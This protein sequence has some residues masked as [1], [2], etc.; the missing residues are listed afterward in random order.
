MSERTFIVQTPQ[1]HGDD[2][3][4]WQETLNRQMRTWKV[5]YQL[6]PDGDYG[7]LTRDLTASVCHGLGLSS[8]A[9]AMKGGV[10]PALR[11]KLRNKELTAA[12]SDRYHDRAEWRIDFRERHR[13]KDVAPPLVKIIS[14]DWG[15]HRGVHDGVDLICPE[16]A[17]IFAICK[18]KVIRVAKGGWWGSNPQP[19]PGHPV[20]DGDGIII[21]RSLVNVGPFKKGMNFCYGHAEGAMVQEGKPVEAG[22][23]IGHAGFARAAHV[24]FMCNANDNDR[25]V[26]DRDPMPF[27][28][29]AIKHA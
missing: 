26:G 25:G 22:Q 4:S 29:Y 9:A 21:L 8:A 17:P 16:K 24:H 5:S 12:E 7:T 1:M 23:Q 18:A 10:T 20:S 19:S 11:K 3:K 14:S 13:G 27:V 15:W 28:R 6:D 2:V